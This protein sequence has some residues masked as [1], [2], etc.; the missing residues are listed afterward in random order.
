MRPMGERKAFPN[1]RKDLDS[2][3]VCATA[4]RLTQDENVR[5]GVAG[6]SKQSDGHPWGEWTRQLALGVDG[7]SPCASNVSVPSGYSAYRFRGR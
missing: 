2:P 6:G 5:L 7:I 1:S 3:R 4:S